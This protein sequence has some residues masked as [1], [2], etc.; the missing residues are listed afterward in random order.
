MAA[1]LSS[2]NTN[3]R[4]LIGQNSRKGKKNMEKLRVD[5]GNA[6]EKPG[7]GQSSARNLNSVIIFQFKVAIEC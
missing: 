2:P 5:T 6:L 4:K 1:K 3:N 7:G